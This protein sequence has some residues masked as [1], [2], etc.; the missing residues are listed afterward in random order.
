MT[1]ESIDTYLISNRRTRFQWISMFILIDKDFVFFFGGGGWPS[2]LISQK[3]KTKK[4]R[5]LS[6]KAEHVFSLAGVLSF[7]K[8]GDMHWCNSLVL[9]V[10]NLKKQLSCN[11]GPGNP[12]ATLR[13]PGYVAPSKNWLPTYLYKMTTSHATP[14]CNEDT[15]FLF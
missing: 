9:P 3:I 10:H 1:L 8:R 7:L 12:P 4:P 11:V 14:W 15:R 6:N 2:Q 13:N 5:V